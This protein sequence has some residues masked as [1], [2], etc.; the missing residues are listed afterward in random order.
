MAR[1]AIDAVGLYYAVNGGECGARTVA[2]VAR[3]VLEYG[4]GRPMCVL[5]ERGVEKYLYV[6][7]ELGLGFVSEFCNYEERDC[8]AVIYLRHESYRSVC[9]C[10]G[11]DLVVAAVAGE[12]CC[13]FRE[14]LRRGVVSVGL[15][16]FGVYRC[17]T[18]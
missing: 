14:G 16:C 5:C 8:D 3:W 13:G 4:Y 2:G 18:G 11:G 1:V 12:E 15:G 6:V 17:G 7:A 10:G 9:G